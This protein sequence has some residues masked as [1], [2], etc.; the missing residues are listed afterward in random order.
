V[1]LVGELMMKMILGGI[2][3]YVPLVVAIFFG[4][5]FEGHDPVEIAKAILVSTVGAVV[6]T[7]WCFFVVDLVGD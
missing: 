3:V 4:Y 5:Y 7:L 1:E 2:M 6:M